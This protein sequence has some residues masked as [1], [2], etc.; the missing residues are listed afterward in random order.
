MNVSW[1]DLV[2]EEVFGEKGGGE[3][4][5][6]LKLK[7]SAQLLQ[8]FNRVSLRLTSKLGKPGQ[9]GCVMF[10]SSVSWKFV[11]AHTFLR[12]SHFDTSNPLCSRLCFLC[13]T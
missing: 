11:Y 2:E 13:V 10:T 9:D 8:N 7:R 4:S 6:Q 3:G 1:W 12:G 5:R